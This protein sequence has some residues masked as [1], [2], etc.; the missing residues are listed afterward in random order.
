MVLVRLGLC[1]SSVGLLH[2]TPTLSIR[3]LLLDLGSK[4]CLHLVLL[5]GATCG[6]SLLRMAPE[7]SLQRIITEKVTELKLLGLVG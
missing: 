1:R 3:V 6:S 4:S 7:P 2:Y 5:V